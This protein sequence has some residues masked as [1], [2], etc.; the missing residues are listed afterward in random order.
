[1]RSSSPPQIE[2][3]GRIYQTEELPPSIM[4]ATRLPREP[5]GYGTILQ[6]FTEL[7]DAFEEHLGFLETFG[8]A[9]YLLGPEPPGSVTASASPPALWVSGADIDQAVQISLRL[10]HCLSRRALRLTGVTRAGF[11]SLPVAFRPAAFGASAQLV[12]SDFRAYWCESNFRGSVIPGNRGTVLD[13]TSSKAVFVGM[14]GLRT[15]A[16]RRESSYRHCSR[17]TTKFRLWMSE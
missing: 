7:R 14:D 1:M 12:P 6:L 4:Q 13:V 11:L 9:V 10:L 8:R 16:Q 3:S 15:T 5:V 2:H 17:P